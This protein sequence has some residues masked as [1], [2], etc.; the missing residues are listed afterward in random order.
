MLSSIQPDPLCFYYLASSIRVGSSL[1]QQL[2]NIHLAIFGGHMKWSEA[3]LQTHQQGK[4]HNIRLSLMVQN[5]VD[6]V[7]W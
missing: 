2:C 6:K 4:G 1:Q 7:K 3:F 5:H